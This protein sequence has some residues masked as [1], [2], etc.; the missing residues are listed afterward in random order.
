VITNLLKA[1]TKNILVLLVFGVLTA[2]IIPIA[3]AAN[4]LS[5]HGRITFGVKGTNGCNFCFFNEAG[6][7]SWHKTGPMAWFIV[8]NMTGTQNV[9]ATAV[10]GLEDQ[11]GQA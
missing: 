5:N 8:F 6:S 4:N 10:I 7:I 9:N 1:I 2:M 11:N 3:T